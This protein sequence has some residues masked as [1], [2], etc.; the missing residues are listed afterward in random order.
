MLCG[1]STSYEDLRQLWQSY[2]RGR[3]WVPASL[4]KQQQDFIVDRPR[5]IVRDDRGIRKIHH[6]FSYWANPLLMRWD[7]ILSGMAT[8]KILISASHRVPPPQR[9]PGRSGLAGNRS[10]HIM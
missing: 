5:A 9:K 6:L 2:C 1:C 3:I 10:Y 8:S 7:P 4:V